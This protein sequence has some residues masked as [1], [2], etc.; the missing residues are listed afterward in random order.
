[1]YLYK[2]TLLQLSTLKAILNQTKS[3]NI[4]N[5]TFNYST[6]DIATVSKKFL[7]KCMIDER[8]AKK[9]FPEERLESSC[10]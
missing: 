2:D 8:R 1:M 6:K 9:R 4:K 5:I 10:G 7:Q 3:T